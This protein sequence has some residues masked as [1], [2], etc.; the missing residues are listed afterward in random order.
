MKGLGYGLAENARGSR[1]LSSA[2]WN[3]VGYSKGRQKR[4]ERSDHAAARTASA[5]RFQPSLIVLDNLLEALRRLLILLAQVTRHLS[6]RDLGAAGSHGLT[7]GRSA[8]HINTDNIGIRTVI[9]PINN[10]GPRSRRTRQ[11]GFRRN[12][13]LRK[14][15]AIIPVPSSI[16][17]RTGVGGCGGNRSWTCLGEMRL[18]IAL[19]AGGRGGKH[20][21]C[22]ENEKFG[23][24]RFISPAS[25]C[26]WRQP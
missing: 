11:R 17:G 1:D 5:A 19:C 15:V 9:A 24:H 6:E 12:F 10:R 7:R 22:Q 4:R 2:G 23:F 26:R 21:D 14:N 25:S 8:S 13:H 20:R 3:R 18:R 16:V